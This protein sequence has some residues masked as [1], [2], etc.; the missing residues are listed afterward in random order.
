MSV[1]FFRFVR[2]LCLLGAAVFFAGSFPRA[3]SAGGLEWTHTIIEAT[4]TF[5]QTDVKAAFVFRNASDRPVTITSV[6]SSCDCT[7]AELAKKT[8][9]PGESGRIDVMFEIGDYSGDHDAHIM[10]ST[11]IPS[12]PPTDLILRTHL[13][14]YIRILPRKVIWTTGSDASEKTI[15]CVAAANRSVSIAEANSSEADFSVRVEVLKDGRDYLLHILPKS[16]AR[17]LAAT[18]QM[19]VVIAGVGT[20][21]VNAYAYVTGP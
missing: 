8:Y 1:A 2:R 21:T 12:L 6:N 14:E 17:H 15:R 19:Q 20:H 13:P 5:E 7:T 18:I 10:V 3:L 16:T 11:D 4:A 9:A